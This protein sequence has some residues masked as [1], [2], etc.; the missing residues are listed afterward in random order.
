MTKQDI[1]APTLATQWLQQ[2]NI[3]F[4]L[5]PYRYQPKGGAHDAAAQLGLSPNTVAK[6][7]VMENEQGE[8][9]IVIMHGDQDVSLKN[10]ARQ[11]GNR[12]I[13]PCSPATAQRHTGYLIGGTSPFAT[14]RAMPIWVQQTLLTLP[15][16]HINAG[17]RGMLLSLSPTVLVN[18]L[19]AVAVDVALPQKR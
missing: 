1:S 3:P 18:N 6:T 7:L 19:G 15:C 17:K 5:K 2:Q 4:S 12:K 14:R 9:L 10:L 8:P 13:S 11:T 16:I